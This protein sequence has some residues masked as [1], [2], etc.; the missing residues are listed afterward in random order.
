MSESRTQ[1]AEMTE[2]IANK[3]ELTNCV[4][5]IDVTSTEAPKRH[6]IASQIEPGAS[7]RRGLIRTPTTLSPRIHLAPLPAR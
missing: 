1:V 4:G 2:V 7:R 3:R 5:S 6:E